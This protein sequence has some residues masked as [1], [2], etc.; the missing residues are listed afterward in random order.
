MYFVRHISISVGHRQ[1]W[2]DHSKRSKVLIGSADQL[3]QNKCY[4]IICSCWR[5]T[6][7]H[8]APYTSS[9]SCNYISLPKYQSSSEAFFSNDSQHDT[10][11]RW[12]FVSTSS[13]P[14]F[15]GPPLVSC[16]RLL[17]QYTRSYLP[18]WKPFLY[19]QPE[20]A[21]CHG[22]RDPLIVTGVDGMIILRWTFRKWDMSACAESIW[23]RIGTGGR[24][25][26]MW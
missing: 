5:T 6:E 16:P 21:P 2:Y 11:L 19:P 8:C 13:N 15:G 24:H 3:K 9:F 7:C 23:L 10:F 1:V 18:Y 4:Y 20:D 22:D 26:W 17:I 14:Q 25:L 12:G